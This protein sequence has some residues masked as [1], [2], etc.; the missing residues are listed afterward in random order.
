MAQCV[1]HRGACRP[2][3]G[4]RRPAG[5]QQAR[6]GVGQ[7]DAAPCPVCHVDWHMRG[8]SPGEAPWCVSIRCWHCVVLVWGWRASP[9]ATGA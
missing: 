8:A 2:G 4:Q 5:D 1:V 6:A 9:S 7:D 3:D